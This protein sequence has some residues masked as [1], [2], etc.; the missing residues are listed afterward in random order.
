METPMEPLRL[1][2]I[3]AGRNLM[4]NFERRFRFAVIQARAIMAEPSF[5]GLTHLLRSFCRGAYDEDRGRDYDGPVHAY[6][7][8]GHS[9]VGGG[10]TRPENRRSRASRP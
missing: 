8:D 1:G 6:V 5:G 4:V 7:L 10:Y 9:P 3:G 2:F